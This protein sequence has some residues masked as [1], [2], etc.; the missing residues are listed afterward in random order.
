MPQVCSVQL[1]EGCS[2]EM[3]A[4]AERGPGASGMKSSHSLAVLI[5]VAGQLAKEKV[6]SGEKHKLCFF[7]DNSCREACICQMY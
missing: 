2:S 1:A 6:N 3:G 5:S 7:V 4:N